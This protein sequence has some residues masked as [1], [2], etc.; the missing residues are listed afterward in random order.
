MVMVPVSW[1]YYRKNVNGWQISSQ[2]CAHWH[3]QIGHDG[4][5]TVWKSTNAT[6]QT[7]LLTPYREPVVKLL[8]AHHQE[9]AP[10]TTNTEL[11]MRPA[12]QRS[13]IK[14]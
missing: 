3:L 9:H 1:K 13:S 7:L 8:P 14:R 2:L 11:P 12:E 5:F 6:S 4:V 10:R